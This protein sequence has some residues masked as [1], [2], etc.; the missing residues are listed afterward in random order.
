MFYDVQTSGAIHGS[1]FIWYHRLT[2]FLRNKGPFH[3]NLDPIW[4]NSSD[5]I[6]NLL[7]IP[8]FFNLLR[9]GVIFTEN[10]Y[11]YLSI[12]LLKVV[13]FIFLQKF[14]SNR[15][16]GFGSWSLIHLCN[17]FKRR[18]PYLE[19]TDIWSLGC[20]LYSLMYFKSPFDRYLNLVHFVFINVL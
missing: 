14:I 8:C 15:F 18:L 12:F 19:K 1:I 3:L 16:C 2:G 13:F 7:Q 6:Q 5:S 11:P 10:T 4:L 20:L 9:R 17:S